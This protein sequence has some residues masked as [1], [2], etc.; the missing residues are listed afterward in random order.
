MVRGKKIILI[1][2]FVA[3]GIF[4]LWVWQRQVSQQAQLST[5][6]KDVALEKMLGRSV[7]EEKADLGVQRYQGKFFT[8]EYP[9]SMTINNKDNQ[10]AVKSPEFK[11]SLKLLQ[12]DP[13]LNVVILLS[14]FSGDLSEYS[15]VKLRRD[16]DQGYSESKTQIDSQQ[17]AV[18]SKQQEGIEKSVFLKTKDGIF[19]LSV[20]G[21]NQERVDALFEQIIPTITFL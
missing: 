18:F 20:T 6:E 7:K 15:S 11:E 4:G 12:F 14:D 17:A 9:G 5:K 3:S 8:L 19:S 21:Y 16:K 10:T 13:R 1:F 2:I